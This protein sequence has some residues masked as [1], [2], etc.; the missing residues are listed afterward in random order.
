MG[1]VLEC[2]G[3]LF[4][5]SVSIVNKPWANLSSRHQA[6]KYLSQHLLKGLKHFGLGAKNSSSSKVNGLFNS[7]S[8]SHAENI[9]NLT[10]TL[11]VLSWSFLQF[12]Y[13]ILL[14]TF[15]W[16]KYIYWP[17]ESYFMLKWNIS[18]TAQTLLNI[19]EV[20]NMYPQFLIIIL[21]SACYSVTHGW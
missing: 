9:W 15:L 11:N 13:F 17:L 4:W 6:N 2:V 12:V 1:P 10:C 16:G 20:N 21:S 8:L 19:L 18:T 7:S 5:I 3:N 14:P